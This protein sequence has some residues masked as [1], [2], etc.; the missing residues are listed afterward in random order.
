MT[1]N[2]Q[3]T[4]WPHFSYRHEALAAQES[5]FLHES[6]KL[7][8]AFKHFPRNEQRSLT[9]DLISD[10]ALNTAAIEG[11]VLNRDS[12]QSSLR[13]HFGLATDQRRIA[14]ADQ[15]HA[16]MMINL[17]ETFATPLAHETLFAWH[18]AMTKGRSDLQSVGAYRIH[19]DPM[20]IVSGPIHEPIIHFEAPPSSRV[21]DEMDGF[22]LWFNNTAPNGPTPLPPLTRAGIAHLYFVSI[23]PF[24]D[25]NGRISR[26][27]SEKAL[28][29]GLGEPSLVA[30]AH[31]IERHKSAYYDALARANQDNEITAWLAYFAVTI[32]EA[33]RHT[34]EHIAFVI[35][36]MHFHD[37]HRGAFN[38][39]QEKVIARLF[40]AG[41]EGFKGGLSADKYLSIIKTSR[42]TATRDL[43]E[44]VALGALTRTG[45]LKGTRYHLNLAD[46]LT[47]P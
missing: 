4:D 12:L 46:P 23:H 32:L 6:G 43:A 31:V 42:A 1:W 17:Y 41:P 9:I 38:E 5:R 18:T 37:R 19:A 8:G 30:M 14:A 47:V 44:L 26:A 27:L 33:T 39:R 7:F 3:R 29:Q 20:Q 22:I 11:E 25:G 36:K 40:E 45:Q 10:E 28:A 2:W 15:G 35:A 16:E 21:N 13:R 34:M 24:E